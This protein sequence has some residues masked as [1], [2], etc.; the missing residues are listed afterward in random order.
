[1]SLRAMPICTGPGTGVVLLQAEENL[2]RIFVVELPE[3]F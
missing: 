3:M 1:M 2:I